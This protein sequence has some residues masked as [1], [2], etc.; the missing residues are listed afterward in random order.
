[1]PIS[2]DSK[3]ILKEK[4]GWLRE[5]KAELDRQ[6]QAI[7]VKLDPLTSERNEIVAK[8]NNIKNDADNN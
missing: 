2:K 6:I 8:I 4:L 7:S 1:M 3:D 5:R